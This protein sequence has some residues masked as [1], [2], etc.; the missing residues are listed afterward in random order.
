M[1]RVNGVVFCSL[2]EGAGQGQFSYRQGLT[3]IGP[4]VGLRHRPVKVVNKAQ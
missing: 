4:A 2:P 3:R 1:T